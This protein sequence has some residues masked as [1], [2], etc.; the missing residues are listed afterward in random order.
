MTENGGLRPFKW[1]SHRADDKGYSDI[2]KVAQKS[3][4][5][6]FDKFLV[7]VKKATK[8]WAKKVNLEN[9]NS[10]EQIE[11]KIESLE[12]VDVAG[13][14]DNEVLNE[15][16]GL[17]ADLW[18][19]YRCEEREWLHKSRL[20]WFKEG[21]KNSKFFHLTAAIRGSKNHISSIRVSDLEISKPK[22]ILDAFM[23]H[24]RHQFNYSRT[25]P[26]KEF[27]VNLRK[28]GTTSRRA[29]EVRFSEEEIWY[30][31]SSADGTQAPG[32]DGFNFDFYKK[33]W[34]L[35]KGEV[36]AFFNGFFDVKTRDKSFNKSFIALIPK[37]P[38]MEKIEDFRPISLVSSLYKLVAH[39]LAKRLTS[40]IN[41]VVGEN[42]FA[43]TAGKQIA[44]CSLIANELIEDLSLQKGVP[45]GSFDLRISHLQFVDDLIV[46]AKA[47]LGMVKNIK[48]LL[49]IFEVASGLRLNLSKSKLYGIC[50]EESCLVE[51]VEHVNC[52]CDHFSTT[53][54]GLPLGH[55][56]N[57]KKMWKPIVD[58]FRSRRD[59]WKGKLLSL[60]VR[61]TLIKSVLA[62]LPVYFLS[63]F[64]LP[65][66]VAADLNRMI[67]NFLWGA[68]LG[69]AI[70][71]MRWE[72]VCSPRLYGGL[73]FFDLRIKN[74]SLLN[75]WI[76]RYGSESE[77]IWRKFIDAKYGYDSSSL[78]LKS[79]SW[80][81]GSWVWINITRPLVSDG[82]SL[83]KDLRCVV[84]DGKFVDF[85]EDYWSE[86]PS[87]RVTF[88]RFFF[89]SD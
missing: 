31:L 36:V 20:K 43:F 3:F 8:F 56:R 16:S 25:I 44:D 85:W 77:C 33:Y 82:D 80:R 64:Q 60:G 14:G 69:R 48:R 62:N 63:L 27:G 40:C 71:W 84:G 41:E 50:V 38:N 49:R 52:D 73:G 79:G 39:V 10:I 30:T 72:L 22:Q 89:C 37:K 1:F 51:W 87:L 83:S 65:A 86:V 66:S 35:F 21:D 59:G 24:F 45:V 2:F 70:H 47:N 74:R 18:A 81:K 12:Q 34:Q 23:N 57:S 26:V 15:I 58:K 61:I 28:L 42:Q 75:K 17:K 68:E 46:F 29:I 11:E 19:R 55:R 4:K 53:Y 78:L 7:E 76:W 6:G 13:S 54:M 67:A 32:P 88:S 9:S 5:N